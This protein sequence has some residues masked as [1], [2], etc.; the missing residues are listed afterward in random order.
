MAHFFY[1]QK[2]DGDA[3]MTI[4]ALLGD[5]D[6]PESMWENIEAAINIMITD[7]NVDFFYV[8]SRGK[9]DEMAETILF[10]LCSKHPHVGYNVI[11]C[12]E[13]GTRLTTSEIKKRSLAPIFSINTSTKEKLIIKVMRWMVDEAD[14]VLTYTDKAEGVIP[15]LKKYAL[16]KK[17]FVFTLPKQK[18]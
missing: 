13:Q 12:V 15:G 18:N 17:K 2:K 11:F 7:Y 16:R 1:F 4:C 10:N 8:G 6:T 14:Y 5:R 3:I 9:F